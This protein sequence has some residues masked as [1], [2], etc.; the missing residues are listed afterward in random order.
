M[1]TIKNIFKTINLIIF[2]VI[3][4]NNLNASNEKHHDSTS[5][6]EKEISKYI[7]R[8]IKDY[9]QISYGAD[10]KLEESADDST[11]NL[12]YIKTNPITNE[13]ESI[14][15]TS[16]TIPK[17]PF[18]NLYGSKPIIYGDLNQDNQTD[19]LVSV[20]VESGNT[21]FQDLFVFT[22]K[23]GGYQLNSVTTD[24]DICGCEGNFRANKIMNNK[25]IGESN[26]YNEND[27]RCCPSLKF[28]TIISLKMNKL[29]YISKV[30]I[31]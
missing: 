25:V 19:M 15:A 10:C 14:F 5:L 27:A 24:Q 30:K 9:Y 31:K 22:S 6:N 2:L 17:I 7:I 26:C 1:R 3:N 18:Y 11:I 28:E 23:D 20:H 29:R 4:I 13:A 8:T 16:I 12:L 21:A